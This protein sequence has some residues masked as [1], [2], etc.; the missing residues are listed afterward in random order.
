MTHRERLLAAI[1]GEAVDCLP[2][3]PRMD[4]WYIALQ[5]RG[6]LPPRYAGLDTAGIADALGV[7]CHAVRADYTLSRD[8][9]DLAMRALGVDNHPDYPYH[10]KLRDMRLDCDVDAESVRTVFHTSAGDIVTELKHTTAMRREGISLPFVLSYPVQSA[11]DFEA[12]AQIFE[13]LEVVPTPDTY[14]SFQQRIGDRGLAVASGPIAASPMHLLLHDLTAMDQFFYLHADC[15]PELLEL[16]SRMEPFF[17]AALDAVIACDAEVVFW[18]ANYDQNLTWPPF[19]A[20]HIAPW[21]QRVAARL[22]GAGKYLLTHTD[23]EN[24]ALLRLYPGCNFDVAES[25][26]PP[27]MTRCGLAQLRDAL[28]PHAA[29]WGGI[30]S[31]ALL[32]ESMNDGEF[33]AYLDEL[34]DDLGSGERVILGVSDNVPPDADLARLQRIG[35]RVEDFGAVTPRRDADAASPE[36]L[37]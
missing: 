3:A 16:A 34:F 30:P 29:V 19:F 37:P 28:A 14:A 32:P 33:E 21:L 24:E 11:A 12:V 1:R 2:W 20:E 17:E 27:P 25:V 6:Q 36:R 7:A 15:R 9:D 10:V 31:V 18:G 35:E 26:C 23:G 22:H 4:L 13:H 5:A 8:P